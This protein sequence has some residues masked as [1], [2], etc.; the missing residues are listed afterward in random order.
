MAQID[1][2][3]SIKL[4]NGKVIVKE[5]YG[6]YFRVDSDL[7]I[8]PSIRMENRMES[9]IEDYLGDTENN[10]IKDTMVKK[11]FTSR[12]P[13]VSKERKTIK[14]L[15][16]VMKECQEE[17]TN[18]LN[19]TSANLYNKEDYVYSYIDW[20]MKQR[21]YDTIGKEYDKE[22]IEKKKAETRKQ[23]DIEVTKS[24][25]KQLKKL[26]NEVQDKEIN[27]TL[28]II[29]KKIKENKKVLNKSVTS[30][31]E[32]IIATAKL[33]NYQLELER[34]PVDTSEIKKTILLGL[35]KI[36]NSIDNKINKVKSKEY[37]E[38]EDA[39]SSLG[40]NKDEGLDFNNL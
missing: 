12:K 19:S 9:I 35:E 5:L 30:V 29:L 21:I 10:N 22:E 34:Y 6:E 15:V 27:T 1:I 2:S 17:L 24:A 25:Y 3:F 26:E 28:S 16:I 40:I 8:K 31:R 4:D 39:I 20:F 14:D 23:I 36:I 33:I 18:I 37:L 38:I 11:L 7:E 13:K 32:E